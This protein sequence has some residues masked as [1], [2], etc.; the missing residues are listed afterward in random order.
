LKGFSCKP[1][2]SQYTEG[3]SGDRRARA[4]RREIHCRRRN[5]HCQQAPG[6]GLGKRP[7]PRMLPSVGSLRCWGFIKPRYRYRPGCRDST[8]PLQTRQ[9]AVVRVSPETC[10]Q[11]RF[12]P[13]A[14]AGPD[15]APIGSNPFR[16]GKSCNPSFTL[17]ANNDRLRI[18]L[19]ILIFFD[20]P[21]FVCLCQ[22]LVGDTRQN[23]YR[24]INKG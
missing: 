15:D 11:K 2:Y 7:P 13:S 23:G 3:T 20:H 5:S 24:S 10:P 9:L 8:D 14:L 18:N 12:A 17:P 21:D 1:K 22:F 16:P 6:H 19:S 4:P